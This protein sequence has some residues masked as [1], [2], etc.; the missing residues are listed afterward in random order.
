MDASELYRLPPEDFTAARDTAARRLRTQGDK[1]GAA[2]LLA[3]RRPSVAAWLVN[4]LAVEQHD[5]LAQ[6][7][8]LGP[9][10]A[11]AQSGQDAA[12]LRELGAQRRRLV[13]AVTSQ[14]VAL[15]RRTVAAGVR[16]EIAAT[17]EAALADPPSAQAVRSGRLVR[18][19]SYAGL[20]GVDLAGA[21]GAQAAGTAA[22][23]AAGRGTGRRRSTRADA[24]AS[25]S[26]ADR[27]ADEERAR[28]IADAEA[29]SHAAAGRLDDAVRVCE[30]TERARAAAQQAADD[31]A[32]EVVRREHDL[33]E[34]RKRRDQAVHDV[35]LARTAS[36][37]AL[38]DVRRAQDLS[39]AARST[40]HTLRGG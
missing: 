35:E 18:A 30:G 9:A 12:A 15:G 22:G 40:L 34:A 5:L 19:L 16:E 17:L 33:A 1:E 29:A 8:D 25:R 2:A 26:E 38:A 3:L 32:A 4:L 31:L 24:D 37:G 20:G 21:S 28:R 6:L 14:A 36:E 23:V 10:L 7:L 11:E 27:A 39:E 13:D